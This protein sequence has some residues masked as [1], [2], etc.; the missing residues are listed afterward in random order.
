MSA[1]VRE[2]QHYYTLEEYLEFIKANDG[3]YEYRDGEIVLMG[4]GSRSHST[5]MIN[6]NESLSRQLKGCRVIPADV[7]IKTSHHPFRYAD[8]SVA[9]DPE[10]G[11]TNGIGVL[12]NPALIVEILSPS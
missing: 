6:L 7:P 4:G 3:R 1:N 11:E 10:I 5:I 8:L 12:L 9:C 2:I